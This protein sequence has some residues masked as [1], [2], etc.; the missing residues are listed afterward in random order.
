MSG[1][2]SHLSGCVSHLSGHVKCQCLGVRRCGSQWANK[3]QLNTN[4]SVIVDLSADFVSQ[5]KSSV[6]GFHTFRN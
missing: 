3:T 2:V 1:C 6:S 5:M 4:M